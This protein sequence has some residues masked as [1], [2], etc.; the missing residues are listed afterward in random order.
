[1]LKTIPVHLP[2]TG[3]QI[4]Q[5]RAGDFLTLSGSVYTMRDAAHEQIDNML[6][7]N[8]SLPFHL[9][10]AAV[11]YVG[12]TP[13]PDERFV[14]GAAGP[15]TSGRM[16]RYTPRLLEKGL[17]I[18]IGKGK[19]SPEVVKAIEQ[20]KALY[21]ATIGGAGSYLASKILSS[22]MIAFEDLGPEAIRLI[23][24]KDF[25]CVVINDAYGNDFYRGTFLVK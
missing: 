1:M 22:K 7:K 5:L 14:F 6:N 20:N 17:K 11:Y 10:N 9:Q 16:D 21:L 15:T 19:R 23:E 2:L 25:P 8:Q 4:L 12:P 13:S 24:V 18:M 3:K